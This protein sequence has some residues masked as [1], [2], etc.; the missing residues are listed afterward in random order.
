MIRTGRIRPVVTER[1]AFDEIPTAV[2]RMERRRT[3]GRLVTVM[4]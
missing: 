2:E 3:T 1:L 4:A